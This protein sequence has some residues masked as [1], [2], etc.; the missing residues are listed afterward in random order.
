MRCGCQP[1][2]AQG[3]E[4]ACSSEW[5]AR[6]AHVDDGGDLQVA[7]TPVSRTCP[8]SSAI[9][10]SSCGGRLSTTYQ[11]RSSMTLAAVERP[12]PLIPVTMTKSVD[13]GHGR[14]RGVRP[15]RGLVAHASLPVHRHGSF[16]VDD[17]AGREVDRGV[18]SAAEPNSAATTAASAGPMPG[19]PASS[20]TDAAGS[21]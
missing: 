15:R 7:S 16:V 11:P 17:L 3:R 6:A 5:N 4:P 19:T 1:G 18:V 21:A 13:A 12:A 14:D 2:V 9:A 8:A 10:E 20:S